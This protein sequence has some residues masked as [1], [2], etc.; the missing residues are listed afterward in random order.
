MARGELMKN[1]KPSNRTYQCEKLRP[2][3][4]AT[5]QAFLKAD[6]DAKRR[7]NI[8]CYF[9]ILLSIHHELI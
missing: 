6:R 9:A 7:A 3:A 4:G 1:L 8:A 5:D 2:L